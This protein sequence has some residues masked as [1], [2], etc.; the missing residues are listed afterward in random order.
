MIKMSEEKKKTPYY[1]EFFKT[2]EFYDFEKMDLLFLFIYDRIRAKFG[3]FYDCA[4]DNISTNEPHHKHGANSRHYKNCATDFVIRVRK[5][6]FTKN[7]NIVDTLLCV[8]NTLKFNHLLGFG[9]YINQLGIMS[10][11]IDKRVVP[12]RWMALNKNEKGDWIYEDFNIE[13]IKNI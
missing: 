10:I 1:P 4:F 3:E 2:S 13:K 12:E 7:I 9:V 5:S 6:A 11:H 8:I